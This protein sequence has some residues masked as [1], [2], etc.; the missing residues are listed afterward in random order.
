MLT[1]AN[2]QRNTNTMRSHSVRSFES[3]MVP[4]MI[5]AMP[6]TFAVVTLSPRTVM[7]IAASAAIT[8]ALHTA[9]ATEISMPRSERLKM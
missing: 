6:P 5:A 8:T 7:P 3:R 9:Y 1:S 4:P 2:V